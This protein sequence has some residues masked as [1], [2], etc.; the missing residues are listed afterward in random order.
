M[1]VINLHTE[2]RTIDELVA[3]EWTDG[4]S[5]GAAAR[6]VCRSLEFNTPLRNLLEEMLGKANSDSH[7]R[8][9]IL[10]AF[11]D[12]DAEAGFA[13]EQESFHRINNLPSPAVGG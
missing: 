6:Q 10:Q 4:R 1:D 13:A 9:L 12:H 2:T 5:A 8:Y 3:K 7:D 11:K